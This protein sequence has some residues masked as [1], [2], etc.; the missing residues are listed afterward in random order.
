LSASKAETWREVIEEFRERGLRLVVAESLTGGLLASEIAAVP[1]ASQVFL[2]GVVAYATAAKHQ[3]LG[4]PR[5]LLHNQGAVDPEVATAMCRGII[6]KFASSSDIP[7]EKIVAIATTGVAGP[8]TQDGKPVGLVYVAIGLGEAV[9]VSSYN[10]EGD[11]AAVRIS[12]VD[13][14]LEGVVSLLRQL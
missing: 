7:R 9:Q 8:D 12:T 6:S 11:R 4:V 3:I 5:D 2:G 13:A 14:S 10:F 1:G